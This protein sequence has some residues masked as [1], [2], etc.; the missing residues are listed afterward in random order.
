MKCRRSVIASTISRRW[1]SSSRRSKPEVYGAEDPRASAGLIEKLSHY[2]FPGNVQAK[3]ENEI[4]RIVVLT[5]D[6]EYLTTHHLSPNILNA[7]QR[8]SPFARRGTY[9][10]GKTLKGVRCEVSNVIW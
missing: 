4:R 3:L 1:Q 6:G 5:G 2:E 10:E 7:L 8:A 9:P